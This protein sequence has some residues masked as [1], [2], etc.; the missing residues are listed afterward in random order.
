MNVIREGQI[1]WLPNG[2]VLGQMHYIE[3]I[4]GSLR[5]ELQTVI[6]KALE[7]N[8]TLRWQS[9]IEMNQIEVP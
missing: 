4:S 6:F 8:P 3:Q 5:I 2:D 1:R 9:A 7:K